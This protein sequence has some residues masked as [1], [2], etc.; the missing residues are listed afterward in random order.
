MFESLLE[1]VI[2]LPPEKLRTVSVEDMALCA[3]WFDSYRGEPAKRE[4]YKLIRQ[5][6]D[7][8]VHDAIVD[9]T[10]T[11]GVRQ[12]PLLR[13]LIDHVQQDGVDTLLRDE[14]DFLYFL[15]GLIQR[16]NVRDCFAKPHSLLKAHM[17]AIGNR[18][19]DLAPVA[20]LVNLGE[21]IGVYTANELRRAP[22]GE[23][24][25]FGGVKLAVHGPVL[26]HEG[27]AKIIG[28]VPEGC[29]VVIEEG[30]CSVNG[31]VLG[32]LAATNG[33]DV[34]EDIAGVVIARRG[35]VRARNI[36]E[37][38]TAISKEGAVI[39]SAA[40]EPKLVYG[41]H[42]IRIR[43]NAEGGVYL[44]RN[45]V[46]NEDV[47]GAEVHVSGQAQARVW[48][49]SEERPMSIVLRRALS[50]EDYGEV[51]CLE[52][53]RMLADASKLRR[54]MTSITNIS[55][56]VQR[57]A[58]EYAGGILLYILG[59]DESEEQTQ[60]LQWLHRRTAFVDRLI[61]GARSLVMA[62][63]ARLR[64]AADP[65]ADPLAPASGD[66]RT[67][68]ED[69]EK[70]LTVLAA[71][72]TIDRELFNDRE[73]VLA[74]GKRSRRKPLRRQQ[75]LKTATELLAKMEVLAAKRDNLAQQA[76]KQ[77]LKLEQVMGR[78]AILDRARE[79]RSRVELLE[80]LMEAGRNRSLSSAFRK[81]INDRYVKLMERN[82]EE[83]TARVT[84]QR[85]KGGHFEVRLHRLKDRLWDEHRVSLP[86]D[87]LDE[88]VGL[89]P[90][91]TGRFQAG[92]RVCAWR[93]L[94]AFEGTVLRGLIETPDTAEERV[95]YVRSPRGLI[96]CY[97]VAE[98]ESPGPETPPV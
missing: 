22:A 98:D 89:G 95:T 50:C 92:V 28:G 35:D 44:G 66:P 23:E 94:L 4:P 77:E 19:E 27:D 59:E 91:V 56:L 64:A 7:R 17:T 42:E 83:R 48:R 34:L 29:S 30:A 86:E 1:H 72:R 65:E 82:V 38:V 84:S 2:A 33:C 41:S 75:A 25:A 87:M 81:R 88:S 53:R 8:W 45:V 31:P 46:V 62:M 20:G 58:D 43:G 69:L 39:C 93:Y 54:Q 40:Q 10:P 73:D 13:M 15:W 90:Q 63:E 6:L 51:L 16:T 37:G 49:P 32:N 78:T 3:A 76:E 96:E 60:K 11:E 21:R 24:K 97:A 70:E 9:E 47:V 57:E 71:Q 55:E 85:A 36:L 74:L 68:L 52:A 12:Q 80:Q 14:L 67:I 79:K 18:R 5:L 61:T 26:T